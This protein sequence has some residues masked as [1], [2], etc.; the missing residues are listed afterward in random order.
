MMHTKLPPIFVLTLGFVLCA[1]IVLSAEKKPYG[2]LEDGRTVDLYTLK[3]Q[4]GMEA[5]IITYG[6]ILVSLEV[7]DRNGKLD[8]IILG[9]DTLDDYVKH[10]NSGGSI[11]GRHAGYI[12]NGRYTWDGVEYQ[13]STN[14][15]GGHVHG[16]ING[17]ATRL[18]TARDTSD[19]NVQRVELTYFSPDGEEGYPGNLSTTVT[20]TLTDQ[21]EFRMDFHATTDKDTVVNLMNHAYMNLSGEGNGKI[22][23]HVLQVNADQYGL[24]DANRLTSGELRSVTGTPFD[25]RQPAVVGDRLAMKDDQLALARGFDHNFVVRGGGGKLVPAA[26]MSDPKS[27]RVMEVLTTQ[28]AV[29]F[30]T[31]QKLSGNSVG[32]GGKNYPPLS[33]FALEV[34]AMPDAPNKTHLPSTILRVGERYQQTTIFRFSVDSK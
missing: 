24:L 9:W 18:W 23:G 22:L 12:A 32:K 5:R 14:A 27:G 4:Q 6:A 25:F 3:N 31:G 28:P 33:A 26:R 19:G 8:D 29:L 34:Q 15:R 1:S 11:A 7:P 21:N 10:K 17:F 16:G 2:L 30:Y 13:L 20:Y